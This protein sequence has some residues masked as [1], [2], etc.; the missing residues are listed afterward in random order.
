MNAAARNGAGTARNRYNYTEP[1]T[2]NRSG[3]TGV[4]SAALLPESVN[5]RPNMNLH[6]A[7]GTPVQLFRCVIERARG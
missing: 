5:Q 6:V 7:T 2:W 3:P 1:V 4:Y